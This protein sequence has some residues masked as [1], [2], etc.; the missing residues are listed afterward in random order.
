MSRKTF[1]KIQE[2]RALEKTE[3]GGR[4]NC[5]EGHLGPFFSRP[6]FSFL[7]L[8]G[9]KKNNSKVSDDTS[10]WRK[11]FVFQLNVFSRRRRRR[12]IKYWTPLNKYFTLMNNGNTVT[13]V[14][15]EPQKGDGYKLSRNILEAMEVF[16]IIWFWIVME[17]DSRTFKAPMKIVQYKWTVWI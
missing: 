7:W 8:L 6:I 15:E 1:C 9:Q 2:F 10:K 4:C 16:R 12:S 13:M 17:S 5:Y 14:W 11:K 3:A